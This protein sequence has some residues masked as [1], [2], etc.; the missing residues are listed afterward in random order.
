M[1]T[2]TMKASPVTV[3]GGVARRPAD[4]KARPVLQEGEVGRQVTACQRRDDLIDETGD[5][6]DDED[7]E[8][9]LTNNLQ[10]TDVADEAKDR[11]KNTSL[12]L[13]RRGRSHPANPSGD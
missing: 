6:K 7:N 10:K 3:V 1:R 9:Y 13:P 12:L 2:P 8:D 4:G 5:S 11:L